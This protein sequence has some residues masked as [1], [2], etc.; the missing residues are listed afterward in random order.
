MDSNSGLG[1]RER[2][3]SISARFTDDAGLHWEIDHHLH[4]EKIENRADW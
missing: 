2:Y 1:E 4:L 3:W